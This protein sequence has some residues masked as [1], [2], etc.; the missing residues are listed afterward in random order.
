MSDRTGFYNS[1]NGLG[2]NDRNHPPGFDQRPCP[3]NRLCR[4][5]SPFASGGHCCVVAEHFDPLVWFDVLVKAPHLISS[6]VGAS[7][8]SSNTLCNPFGHNRDVGPWCRGDPE[9]PS[10][11]CPRNH[12][13]R[14]GLIVSAN[15]CL[16]LPKLAACISRRTHF[17]QSD[18]RSL[19]P[20]RR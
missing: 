19:Q 18:W 2:M 14:H 8:F 10:P 7:T 12:S 3:A 6:R 20:G 17:H 5:A 13:R 15:R 9:R 11:R 4:D 16:S 1:P